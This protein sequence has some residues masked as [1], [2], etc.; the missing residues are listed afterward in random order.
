MASTLI[1]TN[2]KVQKEA[3]KF[4]SK[5]CLRIIVHFIHDANTMNSTFISHV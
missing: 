5:T 4:L 3:I 2:E 1:A